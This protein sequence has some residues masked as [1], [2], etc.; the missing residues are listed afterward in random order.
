MRQENTTQTG[1]LPKANTHTILQGPVLVHAHCTE[2]VTMF[3]GRE[4]ANGNGNG[5]G[6]G[7]RAG[8]GAETR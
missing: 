2:G 4:R 3:E 5:D 6:A 1:R 8:T 7:G